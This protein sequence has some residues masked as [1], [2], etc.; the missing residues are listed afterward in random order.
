MNNPRILFLYLDHDFKTETET[1]VGSFENTLIADLVGADLGYPLATNSEPLIEY[2]GNATAE[3]ILNDQLTEVGGFPN[4]SSAYHQDLCP[5]DNT[6]I[7]DV[8]KLAT[9]ETVQIDTYDILMV[10]HLWTYNHL[11]TYLAEKY[12][13]KT[14]I[15]IQEGSM[16]DVFFILV[17]TT[18]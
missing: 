1:G 18:T 9:G 2:H 12:Q 13:D 5:S 15:A 7:A 17:K 14:L 10:S 11:I 4:V 3:V 8:A 16:Q 6:V